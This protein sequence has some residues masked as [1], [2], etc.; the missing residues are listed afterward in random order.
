MTT[1]NL[2]N[3]G[4]PADG[5]ATK[6]PASAHGGLWKVGIAA[7]I[8]AA[9]A[10]VFV[11]GCGKRNT[12][13]SR[14]SDSDSS[15]EQ[16]RREEGGWWFGAKK[17]TALLR[18]SR[19]RRNQAMK[20]TLQ[21]GIATYKVRTNKW[22]GKLEDWAER[23]DENTLGYLSNSDYDNVMHELLKASSGK[24]TK[25]RVMDPSGLAMIPTGL[26]DGKV[27]CMDYRSETTKNNKHSE[28]MDPNEMTVVYPRTE[29]G[30]AFRYVIE[31]NAKSDG[32]M[33]MTQDE[34]NSKYSSNWSGVEVW[35]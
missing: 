19:E 11:S 15:S 10:L 31:Y 24:S 12:R 21:N 8:V 17:A 35:H 29:D 3:S 25:N 30:I 4:V 28:R 1:D 32:V 9:A 27:K 13:S 20:Q 33:V 26:D 34:Y 7:A 5:A 23:Q 2:S 18:A 22:P 6:N 14:S 16:D